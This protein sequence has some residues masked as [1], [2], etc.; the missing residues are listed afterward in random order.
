[1]A[2]AKV[3]L[4]G[5]IDEIRQGQRARAFQGRTD[6]EIDGG[7]RDGEDDYGQRMRALRSQTGS[8]PPAGGR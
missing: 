2:G 3:G 8:V 6:D 4:A 5:V 1:M 7:L